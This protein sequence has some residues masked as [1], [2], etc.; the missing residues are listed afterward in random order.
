MPARD[1]PEGWNAVTITEPSPDMA[2]PQRLQFPGAL[3]HVTARGNEQRSIF[4]D[5]ADRREYLHRLAHYRERFRF[6]LLAYCLMTNHV[7]LAV[8]SGEVPLSRVMAGLQSSY[9][10]WFNRRHAR[11]GHLFQGR[12]KAFL[13]QEDRYLLALIRYV[14]LNPV[15]AGTVESAS[16]YMWSS[17]RFFRQG[18]GPAWL[19]LDGVL[20]AFGLNRQSAVRRYVELVDGAGFLPAYEELGAIEQVV[21]GDETFALK[22]L[23]AGNHLQPPLR[24]VSEDRLIEVVARARG[25]TKADLIGPQQ[26]GSIAFAR[27]LAAHIA[28]GATRFSMR[29]LARRFGRVDSAFVRPIAKLE[30]RLEADAPLRDEIDRII[31]ELRA[32]PEP[33]KEEEV[34]EVRESGLTPESEN[35]D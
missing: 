23:E 19:D 5:D 4:R 14:H 6:Q 9:A 11:V 8:R 1:N 32:S 25:L 28:R 20:P 34:A 26:G 21:K 31:A 13:V 15:A 3:Y 29:R 22:K 30:K 10:Q 16:R 35:Q 12:Y 33:R 17:D 18:D 2:R 7:H 27:C 24:G